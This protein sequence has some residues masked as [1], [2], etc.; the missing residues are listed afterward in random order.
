[1]PLKT[2]GPG[3]ARTWC[4]HQ[5][6]RGRHRCAH[7]QQ[8]QERFRRPSRFVVAGQSFAS[9]SCHDRWIVRESPAID[10]FAIV[11]LYNV[12]LIDRFDR[13]LEFCRR[14]G[15]GAASRNGQRW[16]S[17]ENPQ[18]TVGTGPGSR[19]SE[20]MTTGD[21]VPSVRGGDMDRVRGVIP[22]GVRAS[23]RDRDQT[24]A[25]ARGAVRAV[26]V[27]ASDAAGRSPEIRV[28]LRAS[29]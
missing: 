1:V 15:G 7:D 6:L 11:P 20:G 22:R 19:A 13:C 24:G 4:R 12:T 17:S 2:V 10:S 26:S 14:R 9:V 18:E 25:A 28:R 21:A 5:H 29:E 8:A 27:A 3:S 23:A 16:V